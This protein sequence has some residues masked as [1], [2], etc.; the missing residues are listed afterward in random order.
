MKRHFIVL[1][2]FLAVFQA[3]G[4]RFVLRAEIKPMETEQLKPELVLQTGHNKSVKTVVFSPNGQWIASGSFD[5]TIKIWEFETGRELRALIGHSGVVKTL[6]CSPD[7]RWLASGS[8]DKTVKIWE[9]ESG[10]EIKSF[11]IQDGSVEAVAFSSDGQKLASGNSNGTIT[12]WDVS[13]GQELTKLIGHSN[14]VTALTFSRDNRNLASGS[15][16][17]VIKIWDVNQPR[18]VKNLKGHTDKIE[19]LRFSENGENLASGSF[20]KTV[21]L[22]KVSNG[23]ELSVFIGHTGKV[24]SLYF[25]SAGKIMSADSNHFVKLW[26]T[27][28]KLEL[29]SVSEQIN[30]DNTNEAESAIFSFDGNFIAI[31][32]GDRTVTLLDTKTGERLKT[33]ENHTSGFYGVSF[34]SDRH[35]FASASF[36]N[37]IKL[38]DLQTG[39]GLSPLKGHTGYVTCVVFHPDNRRI[40]SASMDHTIRIWDA[41]SEKPLYTLKGHTDSIS[42]LA[43]GGKGTLLVSGS[44]DKTIRLWNLETNSQISKLTGHTGEVISVSISPDEK[45]IA[46][47]GMDKTIMLWDIRTGTRLRTLEGHSEEV[48]SVAFSPDGNLIVSGSVD[49]TVRVWEV[50]TGRLVQTLSGHTGKINTVLFTPDGKKVVSGSQ[51]KTVRIWNVSDGQENRVMT[52]HVGTVF[53]LSFTADGQ[54]LASGSEDGSIIVWQKETGRRLTTLVSLNNSDDW[55]VVSPEGFFDGSPAAWEQLFW[56]FEKNTFNVK[57]VEVFFNE[58][59]SPGLLADLLAGEKLPSTDDISSKDRRQPIVKVSLADEKT[60]VNP[61]AERQV[62]V[63]IEVSEIPPG[64]GYQNGSGARDIR[65]FRNGSLVKFWS[66][67]VLNKSGKTLLETSVSLVNGQNQLTAYGFNNENIKSSNAYITVNGSEKL[68]R[69]GIFYIIAIGVGKY[70]NPKYNLNYVE[71][72]AEE[73]SEQL[74]LKQSELKQYER[75]EV[76]SLLSQEATKSNILDIFKRLAGTDNGKSNKT[77]PTVIEKLQPAQPEDTIAIFYSGHGTSQDGHFYILPHD[78]GYTDPNQPLDAQ[79]MKTILF[80]SISDLELERAFSEIDAGYLLLLIDACNSG[81]V[82]VSEDERRGPM[83]TKGLAQLAYDK[84]MYILT[85][86]QNVES[87]YVSEA[88]KSSYLSYALTEEG[89]KTSAADNMPK[90]GLVSVREWF[91]YA[92]NRV[93]QL[94]QVVSDGLLKAEQGKGLEEEEEVKN[95]GT[96]RPRVFYRRQPDLRSLIV[97]R[98][99]KS[100]P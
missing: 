23:R 53:S 56:R 51:D 38:W 13:S 73:F 72:D 98:V 66:G 87:A 16:E 81:Q 74:R 29:S 34:S 44:T 85:A 76:V 82:L 28:N 26:D 1:A 54:W 42:S 86:S 65:L 48:D 91:D 8:N 24:L 52:G 39:Q 33:L 49:K 94:R 19:I 79:T 70:A 20:D 63:K 25:I 18:R 80:H 89:L 88:L 100:E 47:A 62:K 3:N 75:I 31:G 5:N 90:D 55:L 30:G 6:A 92:T 69:K 21:R 14:A 78:L 64:N 43:V 71:R 37:T 97:S 9:V 50:T 40:I 68:K 27:T 45:I 57:S 12:I 46:S 2:L 84:G 60:S 4:N 10:G 15:T 59:Y 41:L 77:L 95:K 83:N 7:G 96:Q 93:P 61:I 11:A 22:W 99:S 58:F 35:W 67:S 17:N 32:N 36:D